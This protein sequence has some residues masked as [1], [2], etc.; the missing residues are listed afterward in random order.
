M[1]GARRATSER[2]G[3]SAK[4]AR[5]AA[6]VRGVVELYA[7][8]CN[9]R[10]VAENVP[11]VQN[12]RPIPSHLASHFAVALTCTSQVCPSHLTPHRTPSTARST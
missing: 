7:V 4:W 9:G 2:A 10:G 5:A 3:R 11:G 1:P 6:E 8:S 12:V